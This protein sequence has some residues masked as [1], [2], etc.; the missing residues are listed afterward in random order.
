MS[1]MWA[2]LVGRELDHI[3]RINLILTKKWVNNTSYLLRQVVQVEVFPQDPGKNWIGIPED[4]LENGCYI[5]KAYFILQ[6]KDS[7]IE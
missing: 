4:T 2:K 1:N 7:T 5:C 6:E 3:K